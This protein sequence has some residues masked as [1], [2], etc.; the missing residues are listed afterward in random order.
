[1]LYKVVFLT[2]DKWGGDPDL[3]WDFRF[4]PPPRFHAGD[5]ISQV[6]AQMF[7]VC[8]GRAMFSE[9]RLA[10]GENQLTVTYRVERLGNPLE[11]A[12]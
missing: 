7:K 6:G 2:Q 8:T 9:Y 4:V 11:D 3:T 5:V 1:M 12:R 10:N